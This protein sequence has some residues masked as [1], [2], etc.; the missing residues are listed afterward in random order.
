MGRRSLAAVGARKY[1]RNR[2]PT[3]VPP[4]LVDPSLASLSNCLIHPHRSDRR[5]FD[6]CL[7]E[8]RQWVHRRKHK[9]TRLAVFVPRR[10]DAERM[11]VRE[12]HLVWTFERL[13]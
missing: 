9:A 12:L 7:R 4:L 5:V 1:K 3:K 2:R 11:P 8:R 13:V 10:F 6:E